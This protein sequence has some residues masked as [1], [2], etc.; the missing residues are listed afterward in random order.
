MK[1]TSR[2]T[3]AIHT[4]LCIHLFQEKYKTTS[5]FIAKSV[6]VNPV[7]IRRI[8]GQL[9]NAGILT[10]FAGTGGCKLAKNL[11]D[12][13]LF[14]IYK[15][16]DCVDKGL[17]NFHENPNPQCVV[18]KN[19]HS[20]LDAVLETAEKTLENNLSQTSLATLAEN[21]QSSF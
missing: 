10:V 6:N 15:T 16:V 21:L 19:I 8:V 12:I 18:G 14:D 7:I 2:F 11:T 20:L 5:E 17:F 9:K 3:I 1:I 4:L 13:T